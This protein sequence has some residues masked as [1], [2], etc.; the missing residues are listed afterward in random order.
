[1]INKYSILNTSS[2]SL[3]SLS[4]LKINATS[5]KTITIPVYFALH[6]DFVFYSY[7]SQDSSGLGANRLCSSDYIKLENYDCST[8]ALTCLDGL[9]VGDHPEALM[10]IYGYHHDNWHPISGDTLRLYTKSTSTNS[11]EL[12]QEITSTNSYEYNFNFSIPEIFF[13]DLFKVEIVKPSGEILTLIDGCRLDDPSLPDKDRTQYINYQCGTN[14]LKTSSGSSTPVPTTTQTTHCTLVDVNF[15]SK[16]DYITPNSQLSSDY[17]INLCATGNPIITY[18]SVIRSTR[19]SR[20]VLDGS[21]FVTLYIVDALYD[22]C[23]H[24]E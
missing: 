15:R 11:Y 8:Y 19:S 9:L 13:K 4:P 1:M 23:Y 17:Y 3:S 2:R 21:D 20:K 5:S 7:L 16:N 12:R 24:C 10:T 22:I 14:I 6:I 18:S